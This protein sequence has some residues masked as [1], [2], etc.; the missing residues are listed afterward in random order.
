MDRGPR[1]VAA[2]GPTFP[3]AHGSSVTMKSKIPTGPQVHTVS[4]QPPLAP[5]ETG[6]RSVV[7]PES[8]GAGPRSTGRGGL[9]PGVA[10]K[11]KHQATKTLEG[12]KTPGPTT[13]GPRGALRAPH[14]GCH[15][16][17]SS[18][19]TIIIIHHH[20]RGVTPLI[21]THRSLLQV[22]RSRSSRGPR[23]ERGEGFPWGSDLLP[24][25]GPRPVAGGRGGGA[26]SPESLGAAPPGA[27]GGPPPPWERKP[28]RLAPSPPRGGSEAN[29]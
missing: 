15:P 24:P 3:P 22:L 25:R 14:P 7:S 18:S 12:G 28:W 20:H 2:R 11:E 17:S 8:S 16:P 23:G 27:A 26:V 21:P 4:N 1:S 29:W 13:R 19:S 5:P 9:P 10:V 6:G